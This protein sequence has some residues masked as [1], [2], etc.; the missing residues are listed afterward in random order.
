MAVVAD[1][2]TLACMDCLVGLR[3]GRLVTIDDDGN[4]VRPWWQ[5]YRFLVE[6]RWIGGTELQSLALLFMAVHLG[7]GLGLVEDQALTNSFSWYDPD[8]Q[9]PFRD[10]NDPSEIEAAAA[11]F[12]LRY[13]TIDEPSW[14]DATHELIRRIGPPGAPPDVG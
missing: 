7:H 6:D 14:L 5:G 10:I 2:W 11:E 9:I 8:E 1:K 4:S 13:S 12:G 3:L